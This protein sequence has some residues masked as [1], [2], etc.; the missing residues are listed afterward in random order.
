M[1]LLLIKNVLIRVRGQ[2]TPIMSLSANP[3]VY[4]APGA[5]T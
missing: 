4:S 2:Q 5:E 1:F 3:V